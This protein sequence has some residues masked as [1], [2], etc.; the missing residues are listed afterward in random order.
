MT[1]TSDARVNSTLNFTTSRNV[2]PASS[3][4]RL[5]LATTLANCASKSSGNAP[6]ASKPGM[7]EMNRRSP[8]RAAKESGGDLT[9][10]GGGKCW[11]RD[12]FTPWRK[13]IG[14]RPLK[15]Y[16]FVLVLTSLIDHH[17]NGTSLQVD[18]KATVAVSAV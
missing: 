9:P 14:V 17:G 13:S 2:A 5:M 10:G 8:T 1:A 3:S 11:M 18:P 12:M 7:P 4:T 6:L 15:F 16:L